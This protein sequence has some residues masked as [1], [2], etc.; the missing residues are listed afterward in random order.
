MHICCCL[1]DSATQQRPRVNDSCHHACPIFTDN[2]MSQPASFSLLPLTGAGACP[3]WSARSSA[4]C[5]ASSTAAYFQITRW[6]NVDRW[7]DELQLPSNCPLPTIRFQGSPSQIPFT[8]RELKP[9]FL[10]PLPVEQLVLYE[11]RRWTRIK[12]ISSR[13]K[14]GL[15]FKQA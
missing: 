7:M 5:T 1:E 12:C 6:V 13:R 10:W 3:I 9:G 8:V 14:V 2:Q 15:E 11:A 4:T